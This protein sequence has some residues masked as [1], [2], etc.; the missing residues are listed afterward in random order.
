[1]SGVLD[2]MGR[3]N[4]GRANPNEG[5]NKKH[6]AE[7]STWFKKHFGVETELAVT[8][9]SVIAF[10]VDVLVERVETEDGP[11][12]YGRPYQKQSKRDSDQGIMRRIGYDSFKA[13]AYSLQ[14]LEDDLDKERGKGQISGQ[15]FNT[16]SFLQVY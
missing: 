6:Q 13:Y 2:D 10:F 16:F 3:D 7:Y 15:I 9:R 11:K 12:Y 1:M 14:L 5:Q 4:G 8:E